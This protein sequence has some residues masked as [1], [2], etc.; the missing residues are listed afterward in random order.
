MPVNRGLRISCRSSKSD[1]NIDTIVTIICKGLQSYETQTVYKVLS[2]VLLLLQ[3]K[4]YC[5][6][7]AY[8]N[9][10]RVSSVLYVF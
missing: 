7:S 6:P 3:Y 2:K 5:W 8:V 1:R 4:V 10:N 9:L